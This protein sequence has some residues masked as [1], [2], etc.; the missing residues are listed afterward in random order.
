MS[1]RTP[2]DVRKYFKTSY[3]LEKILTFTSFTLGLNKRESGQCATGRKRRPPPRGQCRPQ[4]ALVALKA[5][6]TRT[7]LNDLTDAVSANDSLSINVAAAIATLALGCIS[8]NKPSAKL[9]A[10]VYPSVRWLLGAVVALRGRLG[11]SLSRP[12]P[13]K[14]CPET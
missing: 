2:Q 4:F 13:L 8:R 9:Q 10:T 11:Q 7:A 6:R 5:A 14:N 12:R 1:K 3:G